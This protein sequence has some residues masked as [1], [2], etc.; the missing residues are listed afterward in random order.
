MKK[1]KKKLFLPIFVMLFVIILMINPCQVFAATDVWAPVGSLNLST[2]PAAYATI[3][4]DSSGTPYIAYSNGNKDLFIMKFNGSSWDLICQQNVVGAFYILK[5][6]PD[7][8]PYIAYSNGLKA[9]VMKYDKSSSSLVQ[10]GQAGFSAGTAEYMSFTIAKDGTP[11][12]AYK[13]V[14]NS[15]KMT[16]MKYDGFSWGLVGTA[17]FSP[18]PVWYTTITIDS[19]GTPYV[20]YNKTGENVIMKYDGTGW[21]TIGDFKENPIFNPSITLDSNDK[22]YVSYCKDEFSFSDMKNET[23]GVVKS[24]NGTGW[25]TVG[26]LSSA[27]KDIGDLK[28]YTDSNNVP[29]VLF[30]NNNAR[31][32]VMKYDSSDNSWGVVG[33]PGFSPGDSSY[34]SMVLGNE[35]KPYVLYIDQ[36]NNYRAAVYSITS[37]YNLNYS[38]GTNGSI[39]GALTQAVAQGGSGSAVTAVPIT[40][41]HF[42]QWSDGSSDNP[43]TDSNVSQDINVSAGFAINTYTLSYNAGSHGTISGTASQ[44]VNYEADGSQVTAVPDT[45]YHFVQWSDG[46]NDNPRTDSNVS[47]DINVTAIFAS[48]LTVTYSG[49]GNTGGSVPVD[50]NTYILGA[51]ITVL[52][53][54][55]ILTKSGYTFAGWNTTA[56]GSGTSYN[57][58]STFSMGSSDITLYAKW[59]VNSTGGGGGGSGTPVVTPPSDTSNPG[60][61]IAGNVVTSTTTVTAAT[62]NSGKA[63]T[64]V[65]QQ[66]MSSAIDDAVSKAE[67]KGQGIA[68]I[69][70]I[71]VEAPENSAVVETSIPKDAVVKAVNSGIQAITVTTPVAAITFDDK[72]LSTISSEA[73]GTVKIT[74]TKVEASSLPAEAQQMVGDRPVFN[75][76]VTSGDKTISQFDG[77]V[78]VSVPYTPKP[79]E[80]TNAI[81]IYYINSEGKPELVNNCVY[82]PSTGTITFNTNHFSQYAVGYNKVTFKDVAADA[83]YSNSVAFIAARGITTGSGNGNFG[84]DEKLT[85]GQFI[86][87]LMKAYGITLD[88]NQKDNFADVGNTWYTAYLAAAK[89]LGISAGIGNNLFAPEKEITRQEMFTLLYNALKVIGKL[90]SVNTGKLAENFSDA[91]DIAPWAKDA[92]NLFVGSGTIS[93]GG[94]K[95]SPKSITTRAQMAQVLYSLLSK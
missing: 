23:I 70:E 36:Y 52:G 53:N 27:Y 49:N 58:G 83:W 22:L 28:V 34:A 90:S 29:Y 77:N 6:A 32:T 31:P 37:G 18:D 8:T 69:V 82:N 86:V 59:T 42:V 66:Q 61:T 62:D 88:V 38:A 47:K 57:P 56:N 89:K 19:T 20:A 14:A 12:V 92:M 44:T 81:V 25:D 46:S 79:G 63:T 33:N 11:Y 85:R 94:N 26:D 50:S 73:S 84:P 1:I 4:S 76:S 75:F 7:G 87:M 43:R 64:T 2:D 65:T 24:Y 72:T 15:G 35:S 3:A 95:L 5:I 41:Y 55:G 21:V 54:T 13:D 78:S 91:S 45:G 48:N 9:N 10:V 17:G 71:K 74:A 93:G 60:T 67:N 40:G 30:I 80:D 39:T 68:A 51:N 16:V